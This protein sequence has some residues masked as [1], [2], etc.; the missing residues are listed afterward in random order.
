MK[1]FTISSLVVVAMTVIIS[2][3]GAKPVPT[4][5]SADVQ[6]TA[7]A[8]AFT[9]VAETQAAIPTSTPLPLTETASPTLPATNTPLALPTLA[10]TF[11]PTS[12]SNAGGDPCATRVLS[13]PKGKET[14]IRVVN[15]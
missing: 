7:V 11:T 3:C 5:A 14:V 15:E 10:V 9:I 6:S 12:A 13:S 1:R 8:A 2:A 4:M